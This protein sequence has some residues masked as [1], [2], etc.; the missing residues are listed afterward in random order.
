MDGRD[1]RDPGDAIYSLRFREGAPG[2]AEWRQRLW[3][4]LVDDF[5]ARWIPADACVVDFGCGSGEF[6]NA[7][8]ARRRIAV[9][10]RSS[11]RDALEEGVEFFESQG[12]HVPGLGDGEADV[13]FCSNLL[14]HLP[15]RESVTAL[16]REI[17]RLLGEEGRLLLLGPNLRYTGAA[18]WDFFDHILPFTHN[19]VHEALATGGLRVE[20]SIPRFLPYTTVGSR[21]IPLAL[22]YDRGEPADSTGSGAPLF[23]VP[24]AVASERSPVLLRGAPGE[25]AFD[26]GHWS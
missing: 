15:D 20:T 10:R 18:Y 14:E 26:L 21:Q 11:S 1:E 12:V 24:F 23:E 2:H 13:V 3:Q 16:L 7:V 17:H 19:S 25:V 5:F 4:V 9:D 22:E 8:R 6:I